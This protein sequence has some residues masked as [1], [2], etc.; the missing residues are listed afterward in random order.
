MLSLTQII[1][2]EIGQDCNLATLHKDECPI[3][4]INRTERTLT[5]ELIINTTVDAYAHLGFEGLISWSFYN[6]PM[7]HAER[8]LGLMTSIKLI[9]PQS[10]FLLWTNGTILIEDPR[11]KLFEQI[12]VTNYFNKTSEE[13]VKHFGQKVLFKGNPQLDDRLNHY[14]EP[15]N[16]IC[17]LPFDNFLISNTGEVYICCMDWQNEV[18]IGNI[19]DKSL[20]ELEEI[21]WET[22]KNISG[23]E[24]RNAP[25]ACKG[26]AFKWDMAKFDEGIRNRAL[27]E[28]N[29]L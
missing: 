19:F 25:K 14:T 22:I 10:R 2:F 9:L 16:K 27:E 11:M 5:D 4:K 24:M 8:M 15:N 7:L 29:K 20:T 3:S 6:E 13:L 21:R 12:Y 1:S 17:T 26:C 23:K 28:I 18:K